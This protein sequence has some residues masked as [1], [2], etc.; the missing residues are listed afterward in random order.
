MNHRAALN[1]VHRYITQYPA[2]TAPQ[3]SPKTHKIAR[4]RANEWGRRFTEHC[5]EKLAGTEWAG[6]ANADRD[7]FVHWMELWENEDDSLEEK[8]ICEVCGCSIPLRH[9]EKHMKREAKRLRIL[10]TTEESMNEEIEQELHALSGR[11]INDGGAPKADNHGKLMPD[12]SAQT[13]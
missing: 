7:A 5:E 2:Y 8:F 4:F 6:L 10:S 1:I 3:H 12:D 9:W 11:S 13:W